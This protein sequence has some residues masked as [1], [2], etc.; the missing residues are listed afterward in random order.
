[1]LSSVEL[2]EVHSMATNYPS[3]GVSNFFHGF[4]TTSTR[5]VNTVSHD[6]SYSATKAT[7]DTSIRTEKPHVF[8]AA[9]PSNTFLSIN[10]KN[11]PHLQEQANRITVD[12]IG[13]NQLDATTN[14]EPDI[15]AT[16]PL[17]DETPEEMEGKMVD[18]K[19]YKFSSSKLLRDPKDGGGIS[20]RGSDELDASEE[21]RGDKGSEMDLRDDS[22][23]DSDEESQKDSSDDSNEGSN[24][25]SNEESN[26]ESNE[27]SNEESQKDS[28]EE[29]S[30][31]SNNE[32]NE[33]SNEDSNDE[34]NED[35]N[36]DSNDDSNEESQKDSNEESVEKS[37]SLLS[38]QTDSPIS[39]SPS[40]KHSRK[41]ITR[42]PKSKKNSKSSKFRKR[43][44]SGILPPSGPRFR[45]ARDHVPRT[46]SVLVDLTVP[47]VPP[48]P[49][50]NSRYSLVLFT[51]ADIARVILFQKLNVELL[52]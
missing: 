6:D 4:S 18:T 15:T 31:D 24:N 49:S 19:P 27:D 33:D 32:S 29:S 34:S 9:T 48:R 37:N 36:D 30:D 23:G 26:D 39:N 17:Y 43:L 11:V 38:I 52:P 28:N 22:N 46:R 51:T 21:S 1:M 3:N 42:I 45:F 13:D 35:S 41:K 50:T 47:V 40:T 44:H 20:V 5:E 7:E 12:N 14:E 2:S 16:N 25:D 10:E 8:L